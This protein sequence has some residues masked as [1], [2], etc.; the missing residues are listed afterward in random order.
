MDFDETWFGRRTQ[1]PLQ[2]YYIF[3]SLS[4]EEFQQTLAMLDFT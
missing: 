3:I 4:V 1:G 2:V